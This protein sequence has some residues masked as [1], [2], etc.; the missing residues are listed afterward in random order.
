MTPLLRP[1][2]GRLCSA[3]R[4]RIGA[5]LALSYA[6]L[7]LLLLVIGAAAIWQARAMHARIA[8]ALDGRVATLVRV[9]SLDHEVQAV[10]LAARDALLSAD[11]AL[12]AEAL[13]RIEHGRGRIG[14]EI[15]ALQKSL[16]GSA[17][18]A[19]RTVEELAAHSSGV[20]V[21]LLKLSRNIKAGDQTDA[22]KAL[23]YSA[24]VPK[25]KGFGELIGNVQRVQ[26]AE[27]DRVRTLV[28]ESARLGER[29]TVL[30]LVV[31]VLAAALLAWRITRGITRPIGATVRLAQRIAAGDL[32]HTLA[33]PVL[34]DELGSLQRA[35][36]DMQR[37]L[38][39]LVSGIR[40]AAD[41][42]AEA[43]EKVAGGGHHL[44]RRTDEAAGSLQR[45]AA[46]MN[47]ITRTVG[48][49][50][51]SARSAGPMMDSASRAAE[52]G[53]QVVAQ[54]VERMGEIASASQRIADITGVI[55]SIAFQTNILA[56]NAAV[57]AARAGDHGRGFAVVASEV[58]ALA[59]RSGTASR[60]IKALIGD[61]VAK[62][63]VG[64]QLV[65]GAG[66][67]MRE[68]VADV[69]RIS[70]VVNGI[71][72]A[73]AA[74]GSGLTEVNSAV[75]EL[76]DATRQNAT[77]VEQ[78]TAAAENLREEAL[79]LQQLV[80]RFRLAPSAG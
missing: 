53:G 1:A 10:N 61:S 15:A 69:D 57:E 73:A 37:Q 42:I 67:T 16:H 34:S 36:L 74:Q 27:L 28:A 9:Q 3:P 54:V 55:D 50:A 18:P 80:N 31:A 20:L 58:R 8:S 68:I 51:E 14:D 39:E 23:L 13:A 60:E 63:A 22:A 40:R 4:R 47:E 76:D 26:L 43:S 32:R 77:L 48:Q 11:A 21:S 33:E 24:L 72:A 65:E 66:A 12:T 19:A 5:R 46:A 64:S 70:G 38:G 35:M 71:C 56:L 49:S 78:S 59:Q 41:G 7:C 45:T 17:D 44:S 29:L 6:L 62:V 2:L 79:G 75:H 30:V 52:R 25:M